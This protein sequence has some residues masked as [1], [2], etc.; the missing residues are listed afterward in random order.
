MAASFTF[1]HSSTQA[2]GLQCLYST[3]RGFSSSTAR[4]LPPPSYNSKP[5]S[6]APL[7]PPSSA[8]TVSSSVAEPS[9]TSPVNPPASTRPAV[10]DLPSK[11]NPQTSGKFTYYLALGKAYFAFYKTGLKNV[12]ANYKASIPLRKELGLPVY[13]PRSP[14]TDKIGPSASDVLSL[15][16]SDFQLAR[17][18]AYDI[19]R[20]IPFAFILLL[21]GETTPFVVL[22]LGNR[23]TPMTCRMP[24]QL[25]K[26]R[27][28]RILSKEAALQ[29]VPAK[30]Q[31]LISPSSLGEMRNVSELSTND[32]IRSCVVFGLRKRHDLPFPGFVQTLLANQ[33]YRPR[34][35]RWLE[36]LAVDDKLIASSGGVKGMVAEEVRLAV[37]ERG[38]VDVG[39]GLEGAASEKMER[40]WLTKWMAA[41]E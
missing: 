25:A 8:S 37:D 10:I 28:K 38:G 6:S 18:S 11:S 22:A 23:V 7:S 2:V 19:R 41:R 3:S 32:V 12:Y 9:I 13:I 31:A 1:R 20:T 5:A 33:V 24:K 14:W 36:Y 21:C 26:E 35:Q 40:E 4:L 16:R 30:E 27:G 34:L 15:T 17:R 39:M 29:G